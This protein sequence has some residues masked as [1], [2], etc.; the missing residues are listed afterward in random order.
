MLTR[1]ALLLP[2]AVHEEETEIGG[3]RV[4]SS[5]QPPLQAFL[6]GPQRADLLKT[7]APALAHRPTRRATHMS[8]AMYRCGQILRVY[9]A[10]TAAPRA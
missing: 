3:V 9:T 4:Q 6:E 2:G 7:C 8:R 10:L 1:D 5:S